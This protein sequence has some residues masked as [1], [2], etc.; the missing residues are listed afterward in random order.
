MK[1]FI[2]LLVSVILIAC[3]STKTSI[4]SEQKSHKA[5]ATEVLGKGFKAMESPDRSKILYFIEKEDKST[6]D[7][8]MKLHILVFD[9]KK[10]KLLFE[11]RYDNSSVTWF[12]NFKL[13]ITSTPGILTTEEKLNEQL[14]VKYIDIRT[15]PK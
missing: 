2:S 13:K 9:K 12:D 15:T 14:R 7:R 1:I 4:P 10:N 3:S 11:D 5:F 8:I 6:N